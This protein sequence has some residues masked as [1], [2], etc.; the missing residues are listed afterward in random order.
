LEIQQIYITIH[1]NIKL[2]NDKEVLWVETGG[3]N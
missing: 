2:Q 3:E 1:R